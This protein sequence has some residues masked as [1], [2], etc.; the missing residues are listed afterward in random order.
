MWDNHNSIR[1]LIR[2]LELRS[3]VGLK[4]LRCDQDCI[5]VPEVVTLQI[6]SQGL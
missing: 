4:W 3:L 2:R 1:A 5:R 6:E